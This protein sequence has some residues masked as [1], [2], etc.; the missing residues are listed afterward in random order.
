MTATNATGSSTASGQ[1]Q[2]T[3]TAGGT[4]CNPTRAVVAN[5][6]PNYAAGAFPNA[7]NPN[8]IR[9]QSITE[10]FPLRPAIPNAFP[11]VHLCLRGSTS[12]GG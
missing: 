5:A 11:F 12:T 8:T 7:N 3:P 1:V 2:V 10:T 9:T 6:I 4:N